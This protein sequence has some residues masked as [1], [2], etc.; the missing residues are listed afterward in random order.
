MW[1]T[2]L[3]LTLVGFTLGQD[4]T[5]K[6]SAFSINFPTDLAEQYPTGVNERPAMFGD[7]TFGRE[8]GISGLLV[9]A[10]AGD[11]NGC[12]GFSKE[13]V[14][15]WPATGS[16]IVMVNRGNCTFVTKVRHAQEAGAR[17][18]VVVDNQDEAGIPLMADDGT[19]GDIKIPAMLIHKADGLK[20][21]QYMNTR[22]SVTLSWN[23]PHPDNRVEWDVWTSSDDF[24]AVDF[25]SQF[26]KVAEALSNN[27]LMTPHYSF[28]DG[29]AYGCVT[30]QESDGCKKMCTNGGRYCIVHPAQDNIEG[31]EGLQ[32]V[33][34]N[35]RQMC[36]Y[37]TEITDAG[38]NSKLW[39]DYVVKFQSNCAISAATWNKACSENTMTALG[40]SPAAVEKCVAES[41]GTAVDGPQNL[42]LDKEIELKNKNGVFWIPEVTVNDVR[43]LGSLTCFGFRRN[44]CGLL[45]A[46]CAGFADDAIP[47]A[48]N[49]S[50]PCDLG[51]PLDECGSC[52]VQIQDKCG[53]CFAAVANPE[54]LPHWNQKCAGCDGVANSGK[55]KDECGICAGPGRD[56][57]GTCLP[58]GD[59]NRIEQTSNRSCADRDG[60]A[61]GGDGEG[62]GSGGFPVWAIV[63]IVVVIL[64]G[65]AVGVTVVVRQREAR[66][67]AD[68]DDLLKQYLP[69][70]AKDSGFGHPMA[71]SK[72]SINAGNEESD[73]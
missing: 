25:K 9:H 15:Q 7:P 35:L 12:E 36:L 63:F 28:E 57:C 58:L 16:V 18:C 42:R 46:L 26:G 67:R 49:M 52:G 39:F 10:A 45:S 38:K 64:F 31:L 5:D 69:M 53:T 50:T 27:S 32:V 2:L 29:E 11:L 54:K 8:F 62:S 44:T 56:K 23:I 40:I 1:Q 41:G 65:A 13:N 43:Y 30:E 55:E 51:K 59:K 72:V 17:A 22:V 71:N 70:D 47:Q 37:E 66:M 6:N 61:N 73:A 4:E 68:V 20:I 33:Q 60:Y 24:L 19:G 48:C 3:Q 14:S 34:E 21:Q